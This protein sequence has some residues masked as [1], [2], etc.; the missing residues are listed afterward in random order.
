MLDMIHKFFVKIKKEIIALEIEGKHHGG[1]RK[2]TDVGDTFCPL[3]RSRAG[4]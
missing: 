2:D 1:N 3:G 4:Q